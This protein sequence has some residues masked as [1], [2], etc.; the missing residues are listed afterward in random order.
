M[1]KLWLLNSIE[2]LKKISVTCSYKNIQ[3]FL[4]SDKQIIFVLLSMTGL[5]YLLLGNNVQGYQRL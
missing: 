5:Q 4:T 1:G 3:L 2:D